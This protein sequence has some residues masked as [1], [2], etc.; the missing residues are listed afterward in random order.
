MTETDVPVISIQ[1][2]KCNKDGLCA[3]LCPVRVF[4]VSANGVPQI[5]HPE[6][7]CAWNGLLQSAAAGE[8]LR[9]YAA[10]ANFL[11]IPSGNRC[12]AAA[13]IGYPAVRFHSIPE[14]EV[15]ITWIG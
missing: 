5:R 15:A 6:E 8:H 7:W 12:Y 9:E 13:T 11:G 4:D 2:D 14:R 10:L 1:I 3:E